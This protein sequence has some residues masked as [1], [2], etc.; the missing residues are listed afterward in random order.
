MRE[1]ALVVRFSWYVSYKF[2][3]CKFLAKYYFLTSHT[4]LLY[5]WFCFS[6]WI[7]FSYTVQILVIVVLT[8]VFVFAL[9][10]MQT[11]QSSGSISTSLWWQRQRVIVCVS[12]VWWAWGH[13]VCCLDCVQKLYIYLYSLHQIYR[14]YF[15][16]LQ[17]VCVAVNVWVWEGV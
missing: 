14:G 13:G 5:I 16:A 4:S 12:W 3:E 2:C 15:Q 10:F 1:F 7:G 8:L 9:I 17:I 11:L 6:L